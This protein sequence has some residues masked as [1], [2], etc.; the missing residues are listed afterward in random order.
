MKILH[1]R[2]G[3]KPG[4]AVEIGGE[5]LVAGEMKQG[6]AVRQRFEAVLAIQDVEVAAADGDVLV[7]RGGRDVGCVGTDAEG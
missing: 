7:E 6:V 1:D 3:P 4:I 5:T 2:V